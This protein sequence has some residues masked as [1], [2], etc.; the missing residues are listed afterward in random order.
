MFRLDLFK[1]SDQSKGTAQHL[2]SRS[3]SVPTQK[4][5]KSQPNSLRSSS[6]SVRTPATSTSTSSQYLHPNHSKATKVTVDGSSSV[7]ASRQVPRPH[8]EY[9]R[10][11]SYGSLRKGQYDSV[12]S[13][14]SYPESPSASRDTISLKRRNRKAREGSIRTNYSPRSSLPVNVYNIE[15]IESPYTLQITSEDG[16][17]TYV[18]KTVRH[19]YQRTRRILYHDHEELFRA[20]KNRLLGFLNV[21]SKLLML[22][23]HFLIPRFDRGIYPFEVDGRRFFWDYEKNVFLRCFTMNDME[24]VGQIFWKQGTMSSTASTTNYRFSVT[25]RDSETVA[26]LVVIQDFAHIP[27]ICSTIIFTGLLLLNKSI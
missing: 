12:N 14:K 25:S 13:R 11:N 21:S 1:S 6:L 18:F 2:P 19:W 8:T 22:K 15:R 27:A 4:R 7:K 24:L 16:D 20:K 10:P 26:R 5:D 23:Y 17:M 3:S 9:Q